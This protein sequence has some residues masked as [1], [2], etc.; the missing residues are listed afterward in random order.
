MKKIDFLGPRFGGFLRSDPK[1]FPQTKL[2]LQLNNSIQKLDFDVL[3]F[4]K[5]RE[6]TRLGKKKWKK[7]KDLIAVKNG[8][9]GMKG[10]LK[11]YNHVKYILPHLSRF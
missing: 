7:E 2:R 11:T 4:R 5:T 6:Q 9:A 10:Y 8:L 1:S 3:W